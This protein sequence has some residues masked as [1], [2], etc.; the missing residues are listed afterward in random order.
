MAKPLIRWAGSKRRLVPLLK[1]H[2]PGNN[3]RY[4]EPF[5]GSA[6]LF[7]CLEPNAAVIGDI[8][9]DLIN[10]YRIVKSKPEQLHTSLSLWKNAVDVYYQVR[11]LD[12]STLD[13]VVRAAR[14]MY[15][16]RYCFNGLYRTNQSGRFNVP[17]GGEKTGSLPSIE[18]LRE[19]AYLLQKATLLHCDF[20][21]TLRLAR[22]GDFVYIDPPFTLTEKRAFIEYA[23]TLF[24]ANELRRL[25]K[26]IDRLDSIGVTFLL[27]YASCEEGNYLAGGYSVYKTTIRR[28]IAGF[29]ERRR[30]T[31]ELIIT[32]SSVQMALEGE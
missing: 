25:K 13:D 27:S 23:P 16:N 4:I 24:G 14:F 17:Y 15:L 6:Q 29:A 5:A 3:T 20:D 8:N 9:P 19:A 18:V 12:P 21:D 22:Q 26:S 28:N 7:F 31:E 11:Q 1:N 30:L 10:M 32:N 2:W